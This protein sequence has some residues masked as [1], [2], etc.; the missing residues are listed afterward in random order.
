MEKTLMAGKSNQPEDGNDHSING[1]QYAF[2]PYKKRIGNWKVISKIIKD[3][4]EA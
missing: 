1:C 3:E 4:S 2:L